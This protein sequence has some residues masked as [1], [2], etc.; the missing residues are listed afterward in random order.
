M[1]IVSIQNITQPLPEPIRAEYCN[2]FFGRLRGRMFTR[3]IEPFRGLL[4]VQHHDDRLEASIHMFF[5]NYDLGVIWLNDR[6]EV[7]DT[8][9][10][11]AWRPFYAPCSPARY[12]L[13]THPQHL[14][15]FKKGQ[16]VSLTHV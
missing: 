14:P 12:V 11:C 5:V 16:K 6:L 3:P 2:T 10:A 1:P 13:E 7:V 9:V 15:A 4:M 8:V